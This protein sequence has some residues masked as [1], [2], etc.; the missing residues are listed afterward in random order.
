MIML[1]LNTNLPLS[2]HQDED[3]R[4]YLQYS[5][6]CVELNVLFDHAVRNRYLIR[7]HDS[8]SGL[9]LSLREMAND[10]GKDPKQLLRA[11]SNHN[12]ES[13]LIDIC[14]SSAGNWYGTVK[15]TSDVPIM[16]DIIGRDFSLT[17]DWEK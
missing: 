16:V 12:T 13:K 3:D 15:S 7:D 1:E 14:E 9:F 17:L 8:I 11:K 4:W 10:A 6:I 2:V 5:S